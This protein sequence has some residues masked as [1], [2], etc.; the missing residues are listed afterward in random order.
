MSAEDRA[1]AVRR[2]LLATALFLL[3]VGTFLPATEHSF[4]N[5][6]DGLYVT[7]APRVQQGLSPEGVFWAFR[8]FRASNWHPL[9]WISHMLDWELFGSDPRGHHLTS[10]V[11]H[12]GTTVLVF[13]VWHRATGRLWA[14]AV[15]SA[16][17]S[18]HPLRVQSVV[19]IAERKDV[20]SVFFA[21]VTLALYLRYVERP[22]RGRF[23][24]MAGAFLL[25]L[26]CKPMLVTLPI[27][28]LL[29][30][31]WPLERWRRDETPTRW[32]VEKTPL[33]G[34][35]LGAAALTVVAQR[36]AITTTLS[37]GA[38]IGHASI[39]IW[40][41][42]A[43]TFW[44]RDLAVIY[45][46]P[47][48]PDALSSG[49]AI[50]G[51]AAITAG[52]WIVRRT[53]PWL[54]VGWL[55]FLVSLL[56]VLGILQVGEQARADRYTYLPSIG[57]LSALVWEA[58]SRLETRP[59]GRRL[60]VAG[61]AIVLP[62][63]VVSTRAQIAPWSDSVSLFRHALDVTENNY[64]AY[65]KLG[66]ALAE[67]GR[68]DSAESH[69]R[70]A[71]EIHPEMPRTRS[72]LGSVLRGLGRHAEAR[73]HL[74]RALEEDP[75]LAGAHFNLAMVLE[76]SGAPGPALA[77][78]AEV[79]ALEPEYG[80]ARAGIRSLVPRVG[81]ARAAEIVR[82]VLERRPGSRA[83][84]QILRRLEDEPESEPGQHSRTSRH[85]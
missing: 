77:H 60:A 81:K 22:D 12:G 9:T 69:Y 14:S 73:M 38:R 55:W 26:M 36:E 10:I 20:L 57:L 46:H 3:V 30:D 51:I 49:A 59:L 33:F 1:P 5:Y 29:F 79:V 72:N 64:V 61:I 83:L 84:L 48:P 82:E 80:P 43:D 35:S 71:L 15:M 74:E 52:V 23:L 75:D 16:L 67:E 42:L 78:L 63:L 17:F 66:E 32:V 65:V 45:P 25:G 40:A 24:A 21:M 47:G 44:P 56:P 76:E 85:R 4:V 13:L 41:Y 8:T 39:S 6:D 34:L 58:A 70:R 31:G 28:L 2:T 68:L 62:T 37:P 54:T 50:L 18:I 53:R 27:L 19:W 7:E 11:L